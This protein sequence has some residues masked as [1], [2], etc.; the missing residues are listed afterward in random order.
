[1]SEY[2]YYGAYTEFAVLLK[3]V[4]TNSAA[5]LSIYDEIKFQ[6]KDEIGGVNII[7]LKLTDAE[8]V[9]DSP[10]AGNITCKLKGTKF[11]S[12]VTLGHKYIG[13]VGIRLADDE[14]EIFEISANGIQIE[15]IEI[16]ASPV[17]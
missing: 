3:N 4:K 10:A 6:F 17:T 9:K 15:T 12:S 2:V 5:D 7:E 1:M 11:T 8:I 14:E 13:A 16:K